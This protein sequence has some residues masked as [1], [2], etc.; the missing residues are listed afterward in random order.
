MDGH[1]VPAVNR[2]MRSSIVQIEAPEFKTQTVLNNYNAPIFI[3][4]TILGATP[5]CVHLDD[6]SFFPS[7]L[8]PLKQ[9][10]H[11]P[12]PLTVNSYGPWFATVIRRV[13]YL[14]GVRENQGSF[15][16]MIHSQLCAKV[17]QPGL[18]VSSTSVL[19]LSYLIMVMAKETVLCARCC[20]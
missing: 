10:F 20:L 15:A 3:S 8:T 18:K 11:T 19:L 7:F 1:L 12:L 4:T 5:P 14:T 13:G 16:S 6:P 2:L 9:D 17:L